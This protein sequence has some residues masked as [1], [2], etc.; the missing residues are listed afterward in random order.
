MARCRLEWI[1]FRTSAPTATHF[2]PRCTQRALIA[3]LFRKNLFPDASSATAI[4]AFTC[5]PMR[6]SAPDPVEFACVAI[7]LTT[8]ATAPERPSRP[9]SLN[10][11]SQSRMPIRPY[12]LPSLQAWRSARLASIRIRR[13]M[14]SPK[15]GSPSTASR[16]YWSIRIFKPA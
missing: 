10:S 4:T 9:T 2:R 11:T 1:R 15:L 12:I 14:R 5:H 7:S 3:K 16:R 6:C 13:G 8:I